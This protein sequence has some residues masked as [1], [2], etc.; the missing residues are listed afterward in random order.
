M[1]KLV[2][3]L[4]MC[5]ITTIAQ[6]NDPAQTLAEMADTGRRSPTKETVQQVNHWYHAVQTDPSQGPLTHAF[7][8]LTTILP[9]HFAARNAQL[10]THQPN[11]DFIISI[12]RSID[13]H[14][15]SL[16]SISKWA[17]ESGF[18]Q[19]ND[20]AAQQLHEFSAWL[21]Q[22]IMQQMAFRSTYRPLSAP[23]TSPEPGEPLPEPVII[24]DQPMP[25]QD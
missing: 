13:E 1:K 6:A 7:L 23:R 25:M 17:I 12:S 3:T 4:L 15:E 16:T 11:H 21:D 10:L 24:W 9:E 2:A 5:A 8:F 19:M 14:I 20:V 22:C 18:S